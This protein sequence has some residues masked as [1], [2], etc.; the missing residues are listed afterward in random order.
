MLV[1]STR[2]IRGLCCIGFGF[3]TF[4]ISV[5]AAP[6]SDPLG[7]TTFTKEEMAQGFSSSKVIALPR[8][9]PGQKFDAAAE[10]ALL[11]LEAA[12]GFVVEQAFPR[13]DGMRIILVP[14]HLTA[15]E[16]RTQLEATGRY[17]FVQHDIILQ[18]ATTPNDPRFVDGT[19]WHLRNTGQ[20][21]GSVGADINAV[22]GW[23]VRSSAANIIVA[24]IDSGAR[25]THQD[26]VPNLWKN[27]REIAGNGRDDDNNGYI[28]DVNGINARISLRTA[29]NGDPT[30]EDTTSHGTHVAGIIGA[31]G[32]NGIGGSGVAWSVQL[33]ILKFLGGEDGTGATSDG[34]E[35]INYA[36]SQGAKVINASFG[37]TGRE[38]SQAEIIALERARDAGIVF[39][40]AAGNE[41][42]NLDISRAYPASHFVDNIV[43]V[44]NSTRLDDIASSS[45]TGSGS[46]DLFA[47]GS[48]IS[49]IGS[50]DDTAS[51][52]ISGT[53][54]A[55]PMVSG[56]VA[57]LKAQFPQDN[58]R[59]TINRLLRGAVK[60]PAFNGKAQTGARLDLG[61]ALT[62]T[63]SRPFNDDF[64]DRAQ[65]SG[66]VVTVRS[67]SLQAT[68]QPGEPTHSGRLN[69]SLWFTW[70]APTGG[71][72]SV[73]TRGSVGDTQL[74]TYTGNSLSTL[75]RVAE[76]DN[77]GAGFLSARL[78]FNATTGT[79]Y[80]IAVDG[81][82]A[83]LVV[84]NLASSAANDSFSAA[85][86]LIG[87]APLITTT[88]LNATSEFRENHIVTGAV[89]RS[90]WYQWRAPKSG[91]FQVSAYSTTSDPVVGVY[92]GNA[93]NN[94]TSKG[95][96][97]DA[98][99]GGANLNALVSFTATA[100][101]LYYIALDSMDTE[102]GEI[103]L[104][105]TDAIWQFATGD[106]TD[107][108]L[109]RPT[110]TNAP[111][112]GPDGTIYVSSA[113]N[114]FYAINPDGSLQWRTATDF[115][116]DSSAAAIAAD[117][118]IHFGTVNGV[119]YALNPDGS[120]RWSA[121]PGVSAFVAAPAVAADGTVYFKQDEGIVRAYSPNGVELWTYS[122]EGVG[123]YAGPAIGA[124]GTIYVPAN[125]GAIHAL[126]PDGTLRWKFLPKTSTGADDASGIY[127]SPS[128]DQDGNL[129][130]SS[131]IGSVFSI[132]ATG[133]LRWM[134][135]TP[136]AGE[137][138]SSS[139]ALGDDRAYFASYGGLLYALNQTD[140][141]LAWTATIEAEAR[142]CSP[143]I[144]ADGSIIVGSYANKLFRFSK[145]GELLRSW[146]AG[147]WFRS[148]PV[149]ADGRIYVGNGDG[150]VYAF[151]LDGIDPA[152]GDAYPWPQYRH[153]PRHLGRATVEVIGR[154]VVEDAQDPGRLVNL[155]VRN[156][157]SRGL[158]VLTAGFVL[159]GNTNKELVI[160]GI[161]PTL[162]G[163]GVPGSLIASELQVFATSDPSSPLAT[164]EGWSSNSGDGR[165]L[166]AFALAD[167]SQDA[168]IRREFGS[169]PF[170]AQVLP[171]T[172]TDPGV[173][174]VEIYDANTGDLGSRLTNLSARTGLN[175]D[176]DVTVGFVIAGN[177]PR[178]VLVRAIGPGLAAFGV[179][180][181]LTDPKITLN[182]ET[183]P[184]AGNDDWNGSSL[185]RAA[186]E[187][188]GA[189]ALDS[190][191]RDAALLTTLP[192]GSYTARVTA[193]AGQS[194]IVLV[195]VYLVE[196]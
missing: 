32:N 88:N 97:D 15:S 180:G 104:S 64:A 79:T 151:D 4:A 126:N 139:L 87:D 173:A 176:S 73:D 125:D 12:E 160:R 135:Y 121:A 144:A 53:S 9:V 49:S 122:V 76:N 167:A 130:A 74:A 172:G 113:D 16:A 10:S 1:T 13:F 18:T 33:M 156:Q 80:Q 190:T 154:A 54:M 108:D 164:N 62:T 6:E 94:L 186:A 43:T 37:S 163:F 115:Y 150:K 137:N 118:T 153:G 119:V 195:E 149:L 188:V 82:T 35:C 98:G 146:A 68:S 92:T 187:K 89:G 184:E 60:R 175:A 50:Q 27:S 44:G 155:S 41:S 45:N 132:S 111:A 36:I 109:R 114:F 120:I 100:D 129:Y 193:P 93:V 136:G 77:E 177:S 123:S 128:L 5:Q 67:S 21:G 25:L 39:V 58:Y 141:Q 189:F 72:V 145:E 96:N 83:G 170:T 38:F 30:D 169:A 34:I 91:T 29:G 23:D 181:T 168:V 59:Q 157:T 147:N 8:T 69:R 40:A 70:T 90:L 47:P 20:A 75:S 165:E 52:I 11:D 19:Q 101:T 26:L 63:D 185:I 31:V 55:A 148:S 194:G 178:T 2:S 152:S 166:G 127:T 78:S 131:L 65:L 182:R 28:D 116:S 196:E 105:L 171:R 106:R 134:F 162:S 179:D 86:P 71:L 174:L 159:Q 84:M 143:A 17:D 103:T 142:S 102:G 191:S 110:I 24:V 138:V 140:G 51:R 192:P 161:G 99:I 117:G 81:T 14:D 42:L 48:E 57:L 183:T 85:Q 124:D 61:R 95:V 7:S 107:P 112:V 22:A 56:A 46:V 66:G 133:E 158:N 3:L